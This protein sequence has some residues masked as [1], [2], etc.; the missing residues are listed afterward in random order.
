MPNKHGPHQVSW[1]LRALV[2][3]LKVP[4]GVISYHIQFSA[5]TTKPAIFLSELP[6]CSNDSNSFTKSL[7]SARHVLQSLPVK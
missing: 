4:S 6:F 7:M 5:S 3:L 2:A 1:P